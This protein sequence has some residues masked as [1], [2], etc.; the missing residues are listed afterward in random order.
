MKLLVV[1]FD[2]LDY[3]IFKCHNE[4]V[5]LTILPFEVET[6][7]SGPSWT[8]IYTG[9]SFKNHKITNVI[10]KRTKKS[11]DFWSTPA[12]SYVWDILNQNRYGVE[13]FNLPITF[14]PKSVNRYMLSGYGAPKNEIYIF[15]KKYRK[16]LSFNL[17]E[18]LDAL[19]DTEMNKGIQKITANYFK[20]SQI[21]IDNFLKLH[22]DSNFCFIQFPFVDRIGHAFCGFH[23][24][25]VEDYTYDLVNKVL[26]YLLSMVNYENLIIVSD[27]GFTREKQ[28]KHSK[29]KYGVFGYKGKNFKEKEPVRVRTIDFCPT[30]LYLFDIPKP[31]VLPPIDGEVIYQIFNDYLTEKDDKQIENDLKALGYI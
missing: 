2:A 11:A 16:I 6:A 23:E 26:E 18:V 28:K 30:V 22:E 27:H 20:N 8:S 17:H 12:K 24:K 7:L 10:G 31:L 15:P 13:L 5:D 3:E 19:C 4:I 1:G 29:A 14:P 9:L 21:C 25:D